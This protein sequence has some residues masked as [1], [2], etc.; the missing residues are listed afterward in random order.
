MILNDVAMALSSGD[1]FLF[2]STSTIEMF[3]QTTTRKFGDNICLQFLC[4]FWTPQLEVEF[5][6][7]GRGSGHFR[8]LIRKCPR[9]L[10]PRLIQAVNAVHPICIKNQYEN[11]NIL[12][13]D[14]SELSFEVSRTSSSS[15]KLDL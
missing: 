4:G 5:P 13:S 14:T 12:G 6:D 2:R 3:V 7:R 15:W 1:K 11:S 8:T 10:I 9:S